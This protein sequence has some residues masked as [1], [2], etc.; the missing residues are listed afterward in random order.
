[1]FYKEMLMDAQSK[2]LT[3]EKYMW[4]S[5]DDLEKLLCHIK[6]KDPKMYWEFIRKAHSKIYKG[7]Y[8]EKFAMYDVE[9]MEPYGMVWTCQ[10]IE[11]KTKGMNFPVGTTKWDKLVAFNAL[12]N[13]LDGVISDDDIFKVGYAFWFNDVDGSDTKIWD[14]YEKMR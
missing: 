3:S 5:I 12:K 7:H 6:D 8:D 14:Y 2:G 11:E 13:D 4:E 9:K 10:Q 1:M